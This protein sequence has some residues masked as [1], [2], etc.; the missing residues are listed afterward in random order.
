[1]SHPAVIVKQEEEEVERTAPAYRR[2][3]RH[4]YRKGEMVKLPFPVNLNNTFCAKDSP[5]SRSVLCI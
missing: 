5:A 1:M 3:Y 2:D 4:L